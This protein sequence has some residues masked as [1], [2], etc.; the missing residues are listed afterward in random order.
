MWK[1]CINS[2]LKMPQYSYCIIYNLIS[3]AVILLDSDVWI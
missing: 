1:K 2:P 3:Y